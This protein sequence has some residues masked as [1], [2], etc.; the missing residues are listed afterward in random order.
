MAQC[1]ANATALLS[2]IAGLNCS[3][4]CRAPSVCEKKTKKLKAV[5]SFSEFRSIGIKCDDEESSDNELV[6]TWFGKSIQKTNERHEAAIACKAEVDLADNP[7]V[8][9]KKLHSLMKR[10]GKSAKLTKARCNNWTAPGMEQ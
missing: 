5:S 9:A 1:G 10:L 8:A 7:A 4:R 3:R 2:L 6:T